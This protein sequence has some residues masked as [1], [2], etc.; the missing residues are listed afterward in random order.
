ME[1]HRRIGGYRALLPYEIKLCESI[2]ITDKEYFEFLDLIEARPVEASI[3]CM[4]QALPAWMVVTSSTG[5]VTGLT[6][7]GSVA[8]SVALATASYLMAP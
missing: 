7:W 3:V 6:F 4:P 5:A 2:G 8:V 1:S